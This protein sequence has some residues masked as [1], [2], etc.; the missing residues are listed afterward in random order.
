MNMLTLLTNL[1]TLKVKHF[2]KFIHLHPLIDRPTKIEFHW[3][4]NIWKHK[5]RKSL[6]LESFGEALST[7][8]ESFSS[9]NPISPFSFFCLL[10]KDSMNIQ[11][12]LN[13]IKSFSWD[14]FKYL[15]KL[16]SSSLGVTKPTWRERKTS[17]QIC[18]IRKSLLNISCNET[19]H[20]TINKRDKNAFHMLTLS[21]N[22]FFDVLRKF[23]VST[24]RLKQD[25]RY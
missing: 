16:S 18:E 6:E 3:K 17:L 5:R 23:I 4:V 14:Y 19:K 21:E 2:S 10:L 8:H 20:E 7:L 13:K 24:F 22:L 25:W 1:K 11:F 12:Y 9:I 15:R